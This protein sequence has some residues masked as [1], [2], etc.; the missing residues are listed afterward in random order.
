MSFEFK[1]FPNILSDM[2]AKFLANTGINDIN[3][4]SNI[5]TFLEAGAQ[6][7]AAANYQMSQII[8]FYRLDTTEGTD[9]DDRAKEF[10]IERFLAQK[11][12]SFVSV[13]DPNFTQIKT[14]VYSGSN[15]PVIGQTFINV[16]NAGNFPQS[17]SIIV[18]RGT[19]KTEKL[20]YISIVNFNNFFRINL[21]GAFSN[22]HGTEESVILAQGGDRIIPLGNVIRV[23]SSD[24]SDEV[25]YLTLEAATI[26]DG[27]TIVENIPIVSSL[28]GRDNNVPAGAIT[29]FDTPP[30]ANAIVTNPF[31]ITNGKDIESDEELR[32][33][34]KDKIQSLSKGVKAA[35][36]SSLIGLT[37]SV[38][39][40]RIVSTNL[41]DSI[42]LNDI[43]IEYVDDGTGLEPSSSGTGN[44]VLSEETTGG[45]QYLQLDFF[46]VIKAEIETETSQPFEIINGDILLVEVNGFEESIIFSP[47]DYKIEGALTAYEVTR[48]INSK[49][50]TIEARTSN[51]G[52]K[53]VIRAVD[54]INESI[55]VTGGTANSKLNFSTK[56][57]DTI[58]LYK[59]DGDTINLLSKDGKTASINSGNIAPFAVFGSNTLKVVVDGKN[60]NV[61]TITFLTEDFSNPG[62]AT[63][64]EI[65]DVIN[66][67]LAG[68]TAFVT[69][70]NLRVKIVSNTQN[71]IKS[72]I[73]ITGGTAN[74]ALGF[75]TDLI[76]GY[77]KDFVLNR[78]NGQIQLNTIAQAG[79]LY[80]TG[81]VMTRGF[82]ISKFAEAY[83]LTDGDTITFSVD[84]GGDQVITFLNADFGLIT[85][86]T[87]QE[88]VD[89]INRDLYGATAFVTEDDRVMVRTN[90]WDKDI[91]SIEIVALSGTAAVIGFM[92]ND[93]AYSLDGHIASVVSGLENPYDFEVG[94]I[95]NV[96]VDKDPIGNQFEITMDLDG[97]VTIGDNVVPYNTFIGNISSIGQNFNLK[98]TGVDELKDF[99]I[100]WLTGDNAD[101]VSLV[102]AYNNATGQ[103]TLVVGLA[104]SIDPGDT[105]TILPVNAK[106]VVSYLSNSAVTS[107]SSVADIELV[108]NGNKV[109]IS[110][111]NPGTLGS[112]QI[113]GG[114]A[115]PELAFS[116]TQVIGRNGY[117]YYIGILQKAQHTI[118]GLDA[119][120]ENYPGVKAAGVQVEVL[121]PIVRLSKYEIDLTFKDNIT[122]LLIKDR[123][124]DAVSSYVNSL[125]VGK[126]V[127]LTEIIDLLMSIEGVLDVKFITP[128]EN[129]PIADNEI[130]R[131][132]TNDIIFA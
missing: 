66:R 80:E 126:D 37:S 64:Q 23:P 119:D 54:K 24:V 86:A 100:V 71:S 35:L 91:G 20:A 40:K 52:T 28:P 118:D 96:V 90:T 26:L 9:L 120:L 21:A 82:L 72:K 79:E 92:V 17:G 94:D 34:I 14:K 50:E 60:A 48:A 87:A 75:S 99:K 33:R 112:I 106:S 129:I 83:N 13:I 132:N 36:L 110:S 125:G 117:R 10:D 113:A 58:N 2:V 122:P 116:T 63:A 89:V 102:S 31:G 104:N 121:P 76:E 12:T 4:G 49:M 108:G 47:T 73:Q 130:A 5:I 69:N 85:D 38:D 65:V 46:P 74:P 68:A 18:G 29:E 7:S 25:Q 6:E 3:P 81:S 53:V 114:T 105:F 19:D 88:I 1:S 67:E 103:F 59:F 55:Q 44:E 16:D 22:D 127:I 27:D 84:G 39:N 124:I 70:N 77:N 11:A 30:F 101:S 56:L 93:V 43:V 111:K 41:V 78:F 62:F 15:G 42:S 32:Q 57:T 61:Q 95:L 45:E 107:L 98:F 115:N 123:V 131:V 97:V 51:G 8:R 128:S 109:Q